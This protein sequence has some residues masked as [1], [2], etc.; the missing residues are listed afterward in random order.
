VAGMERQASGTVSGQAGGELRAVLQQRLVMI[1]GGT[2]PG[3]D[4]VQA[5]GPPVADAADALQA[6][7]APVPP[8]RPAPKRV[9]SPPAFKAPA[10]RLS[11][12]VARSGALPQEVQAPKAWLSARVLPPRSGSTPTASTPTS[13][14]QRQTSGLGVPQLSA[15]GPPSLSATAISPKGSRLLEVSAAASQKLAGDYL[16]QTP[17]QKM[18][19]DYRTATPMETRAPLFE[20]PVEAAPCHWPSDSRRE[21]ESAAMRLRKVSCG[22]LYEEVSYLR[23]E[24]LV[25]QRTCAELVQRTNEE[26]SEQLAD[27]LAQ[28]RQDNKALQCR[29]VDLQCKNAEWDYK[30]D[31]LASTYDVEQMKAHLEELRQKHHSESER[32]QDQLRILMHQNDKLNQEIGELRR[33][34][35][36]QESLAREVD[37]LRAELQRFAGERQDFEEERQHFASTQQENWRLTGELERLQAELQHERTW[38]QHAEEDMARLKE[39]VQEATAAAAAATEGQARAEARAEAQTKALA[40]AQAQAQAPAPASTCSQSRLKAVMTDNSAT[41][42]QLRQAIGSAEALIGEAKRE[43]AGKQFRERRACFERLHAAMDSGKESLLIEA[44]ALARRA[45][46]DAED[47]VKGEAKL[48]LLRTL[49]LEQRAAKSKVRLPAKS[50]RTSGPSATARRCSAPADPAAQMQRHAGSAEPVAE[51]AR[52][53]RGRGTAEGAALLA[54]GSVAAQTPLAEAATVSL[55]STTAP[56]APG[57]VEAAPAG[58]GTNVA[59]ASSSQVAT[60]SHSSAAASAGP[61]EPEALPHAE[62]PAAATKAPVNEAEQAELKVKAFRAVV[63]D[64]LVVLGEVLERLPMDVWS[65]WQNKAGK[66]LL[67]L[68]QERGS[69]G[70]YSVLAKALGLVQEMKR[71]SFDEREAVWIFAQGEVQPRRATVLEDREN[72]V[73]VEYWDGNDDPCAVER[74]LVRKMWS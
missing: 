4:C 10:P 14:P 45:E 40:Q 58:H 43:L 41:L 46:V 67:T 49:S 12:P 18:P 48:A 57:D 22:K 27:E 61:V 3:T 29:N 19:C 33:E 2:G 34:R 25:L 59:P 51:A 74:C 54:E 5:R 28:L 64:N 30:Q 62:A 72:D 24:N 71:E 73:L 68:S 52:N 32:N 44:I 38:R 11:I 6:H 37:Q 39:A 35:R 65:K 70:A 69:S 55:S 20:T 17:V 47:I 9:G 60:R 16:A 23:K 63:Q 1:E 56:A 42:D 13:C 50:D 26:L 31:A 36:E 7:S 21:V 15:R 53:S 66:D 8:R